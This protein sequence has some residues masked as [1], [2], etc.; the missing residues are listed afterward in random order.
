MYLDGYISLEEK[1]KAIQ[2]EIILNYQTT[3]KFLDDQLLINFII[4]ETDKRIENKNN[5]KFL[6]IKTS[7]NKDWQETAQ[8]ISRYIGP[9]E[10]EFALVLS[11][12]HI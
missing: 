3:D 5:H 1:N 8:K 12:I 10:I 7:I 4:E 11:L 2:E 9:K 6:R